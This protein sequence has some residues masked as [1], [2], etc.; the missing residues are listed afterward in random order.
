MS[1]QSEPERLRPAPVGAAIADADEIVVGR[2]GAGGE[3]PQ[4]GR[5]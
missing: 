3:A 2:L 4:R 5:A 1:M